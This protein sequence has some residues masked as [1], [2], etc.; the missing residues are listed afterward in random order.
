[1]RKSRFT[2]EQII[3]ILKEHQAGLS[4]AEVCRKHGVSDATF[5]KWRCRFGGMEVSDARKPEGPR[6]LEP[7]SQALAESMIDNATLKEMLTK[8]FDAQVTESSASWAIQEKSYSQ[9]K[10]CAWWAW[11]RRRS[12]T[13]RRG[14]T[15]SR[16]GADCGTWP[17]NVAGSA[18]HVLG[19][20]L[21]RED[22]RL[23]HKKLYRLYREERRRLRSVVGGKCALGTRAPMASP[24]D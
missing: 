1:M 7:G 3:G 22:I 10:A 17:R 13:S 15:M 20:L 24:R 8:N 9:R 12:G 6:G 14:P 21:G 19:L 5:D 16:S 2:E 11:N 23:N 18:I 4:A